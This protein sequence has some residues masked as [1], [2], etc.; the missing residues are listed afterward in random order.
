MVVSVTRRGEAA[1]S[2]SVQAHPA[3]AY[4]VDTLLVCAPQQAG[5]NVPK[6]A[7]A[8]E[9]PC[10]CW[11][12]LTSLVPLPTPGQLCA[13]VHC[14]AMP[15]TASM[16]RCSAPL[17]A[18][19]TRQRRC[20]WCRWRCRW[21]RPSARCASV[22][23]RTCGQLTHGGRCCFRCRRC[24]ALQAAVMLSWLYS[25]IKMQLNAAIAQHWQPLPLPDVQDFMCHATTCVSKHCSVVHSTAMVTS[26]PDSSRPTQLTP[27]HTHTHAG[28]EPAQG[29]GWR[30][31]PA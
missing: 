26:A 15:P 25:G 9:A 23:P 14:S 19:T 22:S 5:Q 12:V 4:V 29:P 18:Q 20:W 28:A 17:P 31:A 1:S 2:S 30:S 6:P 21:W 13:N 7:P 11:L 24:A 3:A 10:G 16:T 27:P 8:G